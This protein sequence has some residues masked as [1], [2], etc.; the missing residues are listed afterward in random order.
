MSKTETAAA[1][2]DLWSSL[3]ERAGKIANAFGWEITL[4]KI[5][6][7]VWPTVL[8]LGG[9]IWDSVPWYVILPAAIFLF[10]SLMHLYAG[11]QR[12]LS[13]QGVKK[14]SLADVAAACER[15]ADGFFDFVE[16][17]NEEVG[18][19]AIFRNHE[20]LDEQRQ[21][22][23]DF[24]RRMKARIGG[25]VLAAAA[26]LKPLGIRVNSDLR[27]LHWADMQARYFQA[28]AKLLREGHLEE[29]RALDPHQA[30][31]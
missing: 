1:R 11:V 5:I 25:D 19:F 29:A 21:L 7:A 26:M 2:L 22:E 13:V 18:R 31:H 24:M 27:T 14:T 12:A 4:G 10:G 28:L 16:A 30:F 17:R 9:M 6:N 15:S 20:D 8:V 23:A 3:G